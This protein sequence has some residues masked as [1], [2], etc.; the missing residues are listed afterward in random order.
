MLITNATVLSQEVAKVATLR[1]KHTSVA[2][3]VLD[4]PFNDCGLHLELI[5][6]RSFR[7]LPPFSFLLMQ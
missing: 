4:I 6:F 5:T 3:K 2:F 7:I 1:V